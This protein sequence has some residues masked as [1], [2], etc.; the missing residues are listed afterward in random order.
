MSKLPITE[1]AM[2]RYLRTGMG[3]RWMANRIESSTSAGIPDVE[4]AVSGASGWVE[5]KS[6]KKFPS[7]TD[8]N[9]SIPHLTADQRLWFKTRLKFKRDCW[10]LVR[11][12][13]DYF[14][15]TGEQV[16]NIG[17]WT[18]QQWRDNAH[19]VWGGGVDFED[20][21]HCLEDGY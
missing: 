19:R 8:T 18:E 10:L 14:L 17:K 2:W 16:P 4:F 20:L 13:G 11:C 7:W 12:E 1:S 6:L 21:T 9:V 15:F 5:L 3:R